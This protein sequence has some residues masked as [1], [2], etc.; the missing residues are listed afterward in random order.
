MFAEARSRR[1]EGTGF[2]FQKLLGNEKLL[3]EIN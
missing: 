1:N 3:K 2:P